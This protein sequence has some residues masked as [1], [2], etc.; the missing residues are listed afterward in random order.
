LAGLSVGRLLGLQ[1]LGQVFAL[2]YQTVKALL[3]TLEGVDRGEIF[4]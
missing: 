3:Q 2:L 1:A 4:L